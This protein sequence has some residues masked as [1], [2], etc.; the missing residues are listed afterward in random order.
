M[1]IYL[2]KVSELINF[3]KFINK[4]MRQYYNHNETIFQIHNGYSNKYILQPMWH[5][6]HARFQTRQ[7]NRPKLSTKSS[8]N[9]NHV[10]ERCLTIDDDQK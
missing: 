6:P 4:T 1:N 10:T 2:N 3:I 5:N 8:K 7:A 9:L